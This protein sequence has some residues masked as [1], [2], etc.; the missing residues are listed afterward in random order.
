METVKEIAAVMVQVA[1]QLVMVIAKEAAAVTVKTA[2][3]IAMG[4][5]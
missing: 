1:A 2:A 5:A 4:T 3:H